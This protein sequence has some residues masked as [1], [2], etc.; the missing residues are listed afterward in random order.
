[1]TSVSHSQFS[2]LIQ[3]NLLVATQAKDNAKRTLCVLDMRHKPSFYLGRGHVVCR[4]SLGQEF[5]L[6]TVS[7]EDAKDLLAE[8]QAVQLHHHKHTRKIWHLTKSLHPTAPA[9]AAMLLFSIGAAVGHWGGGSSAGDPSVRVSEPELSASAALPTPV[10]SKLLHAQTNPVQAVS[11]MVPAAVA[12][13]D[14]GWTLPA[15]IRATLPEKLHK[16]AERKLFTVDYSSGHARTLFVFAD[17]GCPNCQRLE[18]SL[19]AA[20]SAFNVVVFPVSVIGKEQSIAAITPVLCLPPEQ[21]KAAWS[22]LFDPGHDGL[23][24]G[25]EK[26][27]SDEGATEAGGKPGECDVANKALGINEVAY[28]TYRIPGTPW[29]I[30]DD[31]RYV[32]QA[33]LRDPVKLQAFLGSVE[34][35]HAPE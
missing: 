35:P 27:A 11:S 30:A 4:D 15:S 32:S 29:V 17:P 20:S 2:V 33:L 26:P 7:G 8:L 24:L 23:S 13:A 6:D 19:L 28:Q 9:V 25:R 16:A 3:G 31:G 34:V 10:N 5:T 12:P 14:N 18:S 21:R 1:M 22:A